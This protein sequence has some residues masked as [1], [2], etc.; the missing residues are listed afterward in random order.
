MTAV[1]GAE[2]HESNRYVSLYIFIYLILLVIVIVL[3]VRSCN[4]RKRQHA[5]IHSSLFS[6]TCALFIFAP[7]LPFSVFSQKCLHER[8]KLASVLPEAAMIILVGMV[9]GLIHYLGALSFDADQ[10][11]DAVNSVM[12]FSPVTF[13][14]VL[15][16]PVIFS[17]GYALRRDLFFRYIT[18]ICLYACIG[19]A[20]CTLAVALFLHFCK[21]LF[22]FFVEVTFLEMLAFGAL[23]SATDPVSTLSVF[24]A[25][26]VDPH[27]F[28]LVFGESC[29]NDAVGLVLF[30]A[31]AHLIRETAESEEPLSAG[32]ELAQFLVDFTVLFVGSM[33]LGTVFG[34]LVAAFLKIVD[35]RH[36]P[37]LEL[38]LYATIVYFPFVLAEQ[39]RLSGIVAVLFTSISANRYAKPNLSKTTRENSDTLFRL[40]SHLAETIIFLELG[41]SFVGLIGVAGFNFT[42]V[43]MALVACLVGRACNIYPITLAYNLWLGRS[44]RNSELDAALTTTTATSPDDSMVVQPKPINHDGFI[45]MSKA[46]MLWFAGL[47]GAVS[48]GLVRTFPDTAN[49]NM[50]IITTVV[51][52]IVTTFLLGGLTEWALGCLGIPINVDEVEYLQ[53]LRKKRLLHGWLSRFESTKLRSWV[54]RDFQAKKQDKTTNNEDDKVETADEMESMDDYFQHDEME[55]TEADHA[56]SLGLSDRGIWNLIR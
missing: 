21:I 23:I 16:P 31:V 29:V 47:R 38:C 11:N 17:G 27:L 26:K 13:F 54:I 19:T 15:L 22:G 33:V 44:K 43:F 40:V 41:M 52:V 49:K 20:V 7:P 35:M 1:A 3:S 6:Y 8:P 55:M 46:N 32:T 34:L 4:Q 51:I 37:L 28:Y 36:T 30:E 45:S 39:F 10:A 2:W 12:T 25:K 50:L 24:S 5:C 18:P 56:A 9:A 53:S 14:V 48:Y 42:F